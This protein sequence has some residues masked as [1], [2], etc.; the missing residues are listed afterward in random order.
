MTTE[1]TSVGVRLPK[2]FLEYIDREAELESVDRSVIIRR[3]VERGAAELEKEKAAKL[4]MEGK[5]SLS[6]AAERA[7]LTIP[8]MV[9]Y[10]VCKGYK[11]D[12]S[13]DDF[14]EGVALLEKELNKDKADS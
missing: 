13:M 11:S 4:Y 9:D 8:E 12:Y 1:T 6:G 5:I 14:R 10:L 3:L 7:Q 2:K